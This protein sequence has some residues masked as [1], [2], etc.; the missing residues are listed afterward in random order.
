VTEQK[1]ESTTAPPKRQ[2]Q[3]ASLLVCLPALPVFA[4]LFYDLIIHQGNLTANVAMQLEAARRMATGELVYVD[5]WDW[6]QPIV[7]YLATLPLALYQLFESL[8]TFVR[9]EL[10][11]KSLN[12][13]FVLVSFVLCLTVIRKASVTCLQAKSLELPLAVA[14]PIACYAVRFQFGEVQS[15]FILAFM[16]YLLLRWLRYQ[17]S[18]QTQAQTKI[19]TQIQIPAGL[20]Y[21]IGLLA[22]LGVCM[23]VVYWPLLIL[24]EILFAIQCGRFKFSTARF[25]AGGLFTAVIIALSAFLSLNSLQQNAFIHWIMPLRIAILKL[26]DLA[27]LPL[28]V[29]PDRRDV[30]YLLSLAM[31]LGSILQKHNRLYMALMAAALWGL[32]IFICEGQGLSEQLVVCTYSTTVIL[33]LSIFDCLIFLARFLHNLRAPWNITWSFRTVLLVTTIMTSIVAA[34]FLKQAQTAFDQALSVRPTN[35]APRLPDIEQTLEKY[36][37]WQDEV[38]LLSYSPKSIYPTITNLDRHQCGYLLSAQPLFLLTLLEETYGLTKDLKDFRTQLVQK[39]TRDFTSGQPKLILVDI[40]RE[41]E[42]LEKYKLLPI[43]EEKYDRIGL[44][45]YYNVYRE[46][47]ENIGLNLAFAIYHLKSEAPVMRR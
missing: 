22:G 28:S 23:D 34:T 42:T 2:P 19:Q 8:H 3:L 26:F 10:I 9:L 41:E 17:E 11:S 27:L 29:S 20:A 45:N 46:P 18:S 14:L 31:V 30:I 32:T 15:Q 36:T 33:V 4:A 47:R 21:I 25:E 35:G 43:L 1:P 12:M 37:K 44:C 39:M 24:L 38:I 6:S 13:I 5:F 40:M 7:V 16:P